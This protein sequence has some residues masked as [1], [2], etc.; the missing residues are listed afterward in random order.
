MNSFSTEIGSRGYHVY[1]D[2]T[3]RDIRVNQPVVVCQETNPLSKVY[4]PCCCKITIARRGRIGPVTVGHI[5]REISRYVYYFLRSG[6]VS[7][8]V[9]DTQYKPSPIPAGGLKV[10]LWLRFTHP[11]MWTIDQLKDFVS[12]QTER[13]GKTF[14]IDDDDDEEA[15]ERV[16]DEQEEVQEIMVKV[17]EVGEC[18]EEKEEPDN[19]G[20]INVHEIIDAE[21]NGGRR[22]DYFF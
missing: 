18:S 9:A 4:D 6:A 17:D 5:P 21:T 11:K 15:D 19:V 22:K 1:R 12:K 7:G 13:M 20:T 14:S 8:T 3:W 2:T 10:P 16:E